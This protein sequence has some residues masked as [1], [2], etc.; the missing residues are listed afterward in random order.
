VLV[1]AT[2]A[3]VGV[4][5]FIGLQ[6]LK[7]DVKYEVGA[8]VLREADGTAALT[9]CSTTG[10]FRIVSS[11]SSQSQCQDARQ[12]YLEVP[13]GAGSVSYRCLEPAA[14]PPATE[15]PVDPTATATAAT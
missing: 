8:C 6:W 4:G 7:T 5:S 10:A 11:V 13:E 3:V 2:L 14:A 12:A 15:A 9:E 1:V